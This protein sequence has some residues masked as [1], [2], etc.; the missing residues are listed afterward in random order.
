MGKVT[1]QKKLLP[2]VQSV[3]CVTIK[4]MRGSHRA[5]MKLSFMEET[6]DL[7]AVQ[8]QVHE[9]KRRFGSLDDVKWGR[10]FKKI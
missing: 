7:Q 9:V 1:G 5:N 8:C 3:A 4:D 6:D 2:F 10:M